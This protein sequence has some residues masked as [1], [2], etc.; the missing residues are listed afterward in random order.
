MGNALD[1]LAHCYGI[2]HTYV[3]ATGRRRQISRSAKSGVLKAMGVAAESEEQVRASLAVAPKPRQFKMAAAGARC[4]VPAWLEV[5]RAWGL[6]CQLY[7]LRSPRN[8]GIGDFEDLASLAEHSAALGADFLGTNPLHALFMADPTRRSPYSPSHRRFLN[9]LYI[10]VDRIAPA[11]EQLASRPAGAAASD[12]VDYPSV[13]HRKRTAFEDA[14]R[15]FRKNAQKESR[16]S[17]TFQAFCSE[18]GGSLEAFATFEALSEKLVAAGFGCGWHNWPEACRRI[19]SPAVEAFRRDNHECILY[20]KWLQWIADE[21]LK[22]AQRRALAAGMRIGLLLDLAVG[23]AP[24]GA[25]TWADP[26]L[27]VSG[28]R[29]GSPPDLFNSKGQDWGLA[30]LS[31]TALVERNLQPF[32][33]LISDSMAH[34]GAIRVD[35]VMG[36][37]WLYWIPEGG[38][39]T[40]GA[41]VRYP[42]TDMVRRMAT[43]SHEN[44]A[45]V[46]GEDLGTVPR[47]FRNVM[48]A[49]EIQ[50]YRVL[51]FEREN[52]EF[53][54][55]HAYARETCACVSTHDLPTLAGWW[56]GRDIELRERLGRIDGKGAAV[57][58]AERQRD[59]RALLRALGVARVLPDYLE[60]MVDGTLPVAN[61]LPQALAVAVHAFIARTGSRLVAVQLEDLVGEIEQPNMP[62]T[63]DEHPNWQRKLRVEI[64]GLSALPQV[65]EIAAI[66]TRERPRST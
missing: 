5:G 65:R 36:L 13:S 24:D 4:F 54:E 14:F 30:P 66:M 8:Q 45:L 46:I 56:T 48:R 33:D 50:G 57:Q 6:T 7:G 39:P 25:A 19:E 11:G 62:G 22:E 55:P 63:I 40:D 47:G 23:V 28:A 59:R 17:S 58:R 29:I 9:P 60:P 34:A 41:Y 43:A 21:Q 38:D 35:H 42:M 64:D 52:E 32:Q 18:R 2:S 3:D 49:A 1:K 53:R 15:R 51:F 44:C 37:K 27:V 61:E 10:A 31:P 20:H 16:Q 12:L 26:D